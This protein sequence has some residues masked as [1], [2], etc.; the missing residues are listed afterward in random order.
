MDLNRISFRNRVHG[1]IEAQ[2]MRVDVIPA[3]SSGLPA[4][5]ETK[6]T[7]ASGIKCSAVAAAFIC[8]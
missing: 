6:I 2:A 4:A 3:G 8:G 5:L 1:W 7:R